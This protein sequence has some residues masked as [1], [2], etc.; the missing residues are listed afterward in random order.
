MQG[1]FKKILKDEWSDSV[2]KPDIVIADPPRQG[3][4]PKVV[5]RIM[6]LAPPHIIYVSC[7]PA[8]QARDLA[9]LKEKYEV[10]AIQPVDMFPPYGPCGER[11]RFLRMKTG[12]NHEN[13]P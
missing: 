6:N 11:G 8:T 2:G 7:K 12:D 10:V 5:E 1:I 4:A 3:M 13:S 9:I